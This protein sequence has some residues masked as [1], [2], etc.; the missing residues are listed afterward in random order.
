M[1][2]LLLIL[3]GLCLGLGL[4]LPLVAAGDPAPLPHNA[5]SYASPFW[6]TVVPGVSVAARPLAGAVVATVPGQGDKA[7]LLV[8]WPSGQVSVLVEEP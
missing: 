8:V 4:W 6:T 7:R 3:L 1:R 5:G 2:S